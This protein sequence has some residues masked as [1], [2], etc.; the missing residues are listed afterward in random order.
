MDKLTHFQQVGLFMETFG[1]DVRKDFYMPS[2]K[3]M[4]LRLSLILEEFIE[5]YDSCITS[6]G[7]YEAESDIRANLMDALRKINDINDDA[8]Q[9]DHI[10]FA[11]ALTDIEYV[12]L[13][14]GHAVGVDLDVTFDEV[15]RSNMS[16]L[17]PDG[18]PMYRE[19][20]KVMKG[21]NYTPPD[22]MVAIARSKA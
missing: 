10:A 20:G 8:I 11:D 19:D 1:Q 13:G 3:V 5:L 14:A 17:G 18:K 12:T 2:P 7:A 16:K 22:L 9:L 4:K 21:P 6:T 15:Q